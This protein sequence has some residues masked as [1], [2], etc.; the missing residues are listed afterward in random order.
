VV[1]PFSRVSPAAAAALAVGPFTDRPDP[2]FLIG[3]VVDVAADGTISF[4]DLDDRV[5]ESKLQSKTQIWKNGEWQVAPLAA[6]DC[7]MGRGELDAGGTLLI[8]RVW[9]NILNIR[10]TLDS[11]LAQGK[12]VRVVAQDRSQWQLAAR[13]DTIVRDRHTPC[14][15]SALG[16]S[17]DIGHMNLHVS[18]PL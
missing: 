4:L 18:A 12:T 14:A 7:V 6:N 10:G 11:T 17:F 16:G 13:P 9:A 2:N 1:A 8:D 5:R 15:F 3:R